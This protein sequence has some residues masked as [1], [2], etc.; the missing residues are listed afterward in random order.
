[1]FLILMLSLLV[2]LI[3]IEKIDKEKFAYLLFVNGCIVNFV[4]YLTT[5]ALSVALL[6]LIYYAYKIQQ[7]KLE[8]NNSNFLEILF[9]IIKLGLIWSIG[10][11]MTWFSKFILADIFCNTGSLSSGL[12]QMTFR[13]GGE[14]AGA[15]VLWKYANWPHIKRMFIMTNIIGILVLF[16]SDRVKFMIPSKKDIM[17]YTSL[18]IIACIPIAWMIL[19]YNHT[20]YHYNLFTYRN[21]LIVLIVFYYVITIDKPKESKV[22]KKNE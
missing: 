13:M 12:S 3:N 18:I 16:V 5:P 21:W 20:I 9:E 17:N 10:Y 6:L 7:N 4:D 22:E 2:L 1:M 8:T 14:I 19:L 11:G 15:E